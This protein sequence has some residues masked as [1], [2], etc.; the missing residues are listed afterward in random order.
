MSDTASA[1]DRKY[2]LS[3]SSAADS[4]LFDVIVHLLAPQPG[5]RILDVGCNTG[6][7]V[8]R[9]AS[10]GC[11]PL[12]IDI[13]PAAIAIARERH[14]QLQF[15]VAEMS[16]L[17][18]SDF[19]AIIASH[20]IEHL[21]QPEELLSAARQRLKAD[22]TL[23]LVTP[24]RNAF[25]HRFCHGIR[26]IPFFHDPT[27]VRFFFAARIATGDRQSRVR[28]GANRDLLVLSPVR[29][30]LAAES[31]GTDSHVRYGRS[32][33]CAR[34]SLLRPTQALHG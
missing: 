23:I 15:Q 30:P 10:L 29:E 18:D 9:V 32:S 26:G 13:N 27:H 25:L 11:E 17:S 33:V 31:T 7:L 19:D 21:A 12:G 2:A 14:P 5:W 22:G 28:A 8:A 20:L 34:K 1:Y 4:W 6:E 3:R 24:N 16:Q